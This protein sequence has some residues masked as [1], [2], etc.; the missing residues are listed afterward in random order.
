MADTT[1]DSTLQ[2]EAWDSK[3]FKEY[4][5]ESQFAP[6]TGTSENAIIQVK[7]TSGRPGA[8][9]TIP[10]VRKLDGAGVTGNTSLDGAEEHLDQYGHQ[11][12]T[13]YLR[14]GVRVSRE[15]EMK[16]VIDIRDA[17][18]MMLKVWMQDKTRSEIIRELQSPVIGG[19]VSY[20]DAT[21]VQKDAW[22]AANSDRV[23]FG[24]LKSNNSSNDHS[25]SLSNVDT[26][27]DTFTSAKASL[28]KRMAKSP[29][30][31]A[32]RPYRTGTGGEIYIVFAGSMPFRDFKNDST[33]QQANR[34]AGVRGKDNP[35]F[36]D[37]ALLWDGMVVVEV[38]EILSIGNVG[39]TSAPV[40]TV[41]LCGAQ[42]IGIG[43][44]SRL[45]TIVDEDKD[46]KFKPG[47]AVQEC[48]GIEKLFFNSVQ[49][50]MVTGYFAAA[51]DA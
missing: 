18:R 14:H 32:I 9:L 26:T 39:A 45:K 43:Y 15:E 13:T 7:D 23:L 3:L 20:A 48:R 47:V 21:E 11:I 41:L 8:S 30:N 50:G 10:L 31:G 29:T 22:L 40:H 35:I 42:A 27:N 2:A 28:M 6:F 34:D 44:K 16:T 19:G 25:A 5:R 17:A 38:P 51:A 33:I 46:Y 37:G 12:T 24:A 36:V 49:H 1:V 4:Q